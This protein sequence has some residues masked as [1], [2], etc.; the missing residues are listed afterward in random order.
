MRIT[1]HR[2]HQIGCCITELV[3]SKGIKIFIDVGHN[4]PKGDR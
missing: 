2:P 3:S 4:L 1:L